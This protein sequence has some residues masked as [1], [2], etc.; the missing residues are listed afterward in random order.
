ME[1]SHKSMHVV[2]DFETTALKIPLLTSI[3]H[4]TVRLYRLPFRAFYLELQYNTLKQK[5][6]GVKGAFLTDLYF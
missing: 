1:Q 2:Y 6:N 3:G 4:P 5:T